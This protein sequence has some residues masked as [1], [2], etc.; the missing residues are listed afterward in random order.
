MAT[1]K[2]TDRKAK[3]TLNILGWE[4]EPSDKWCVYETKYEDENVKLL[5]GENLQ[6]APSKPFKFYC[7]GTET[8]NGFI[9][10]AGELNR[11]LHRTGKKGRNYEMDWETEEF[12]EN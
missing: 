8:I 3:F 4:F 1:L 11:I 2:S 10:F 6:K 7:E 12:L 5:I 9:N